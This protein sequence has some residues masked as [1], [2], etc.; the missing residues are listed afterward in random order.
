[1]K[2]FLDNGSYYLEIWNI[3]PPVL[4]A[5]ADD[6]SFR[7]KEIIDLMKMFGDYYMFTWSYTSGNAMSKRIRKRRRAFGR[8]RELSKDIVVE[9]TRF[10]GKEEVFFDIAKVSRKGAGDVERMAKD[11]RWGITSGLIL[12]KDKLDCFPSELVELFRISENEVDVTKREEKKLLVV[13]YINSLLEQGRLP[14]QIV[15]GPDAEQFLLVPIGELDVG[16][17]VEFIDE[18]DFE[19]WTS[20]GFEMRSIR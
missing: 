3:R 1:M 4:W 12:S 19:R 9:M 18:K 6:Y 7:E 8:F 14:I 16:M 5:K 13:K 20:R 17:G 10:I 11:S 2:Y 15:E